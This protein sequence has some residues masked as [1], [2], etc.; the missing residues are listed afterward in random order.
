MCLSSVP[1]LNEIHP[2]KSWLKVI[3]LNRCEEEEEI[4]KKIKQFSETY[5]YFKNFLA[6]FPQI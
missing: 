3:V 6:Y 4:M 1:N 2:R 5:N